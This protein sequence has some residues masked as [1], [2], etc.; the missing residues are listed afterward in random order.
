MILGDSTSCN[1][2]FQ[3]DES[4]IFI[5]EENEDDERSSGAA[6]VAHASIAL[7]IALVLAVGT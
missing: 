1:F 2:A 3:S 4:D 7:F 5:V 6:S